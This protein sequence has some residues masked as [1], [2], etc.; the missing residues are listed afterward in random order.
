MSANKNFTND[1]SKETSPYLLQHAHN[2]VQW[3]PWSETLFETATAADKPILLSIGY[4]ACHWCHVMERES[5]E[6][7]AVADYMN[8]HFINIK[9]DRE[10]RPDIDHIYMD[11]LQAMTGSGGWPLNIFLLPNGQPFYGGTY[12][13]PNA[14]QNRASWMDVLKGIKVA[15]D[16]NREKLVEQAT[17]L[18]AHLL[19]SNIKAQQSRTLDTIATKEEF[20]LIAERLLQNADTQWG[21][22]GA[23]PKFPQTFSIQVLFRNY[24]QNKD[25]A[26]IVHAIRSIDKMIQGG[27]YDHVGGGFSRYSVDA[28]WQAPH[29]E[30]MLYDNAL[31]LGTLAEAYQITKKSIYQ[32]VIHATFTFLQRELFNGNGGYYAALDADSE[33]VEGKF[34]TWSYDELKSVIAPEIF[35]AFIAYYQ[36]TPNGNWEHTNILWTQNALEKEWEPAW[37]NELKKLFDKRAMRV[38]PALD[39]KVI[40]G[41]NAMLIVGFCKINAATGN[42]IYKKAAIECMDWLEANLYHADEHYF[43]HSIANDKPKAHAFLDDYANLIQAYIQLQEMTGDTSYLFKAKKWMDYVLLNFIDEDGLYFYYTASYQKDVIIRK[44]ESYDGAQ[45]SGNALICSSLYYLGQVFDLTEWRIQ[46]EKMIHSM[47]PTLLQYPSS[48]GFWA[49][50]FYQMSTGMI[51]LV[52]VGPTVYESLSTLNAAFVPNAIRLMSQVQEDSIPLLKG[53]QWVENQFFIC[54]NNSCSVPMAN[55]D[56]ILANI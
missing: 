36:V 6:D 35:D 27:I 18:T 9:V 30:K 52:G 2:P 41:W 28:M 24:F 31:I 22:F 8:T 53:K 51:E 23:A 42:E 15:F 21:G 44:K 50:S 46:A 43:Y 26:S 13:P 49:Q 37:Q 3:M 48:F 16:S 20:Q 14:M 11:A 7:E 45:P 1:L 54:K 40:L 56:L 34:Y 38:P 47:R 12:F 5:F 29:F 17:H 25:Q 32:E 4:A 10:E 55:V 19:Q 33:G 39:H